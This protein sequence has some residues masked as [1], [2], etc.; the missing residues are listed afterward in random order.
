MNLFTNL[1]SMRFQ[2]HQL[3]SWIP[4]E[5]TTRPLILT[6]K[7]IHRVLKKKGRERE[8]I[9]GRKKTKNK[10]TKKPPNIKPTKN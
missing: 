6:E 4:S 8:E 5:I 9:E 10:H 3:L 7:T 2:N 1:I